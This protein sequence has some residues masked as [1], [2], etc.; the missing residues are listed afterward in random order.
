[1]ANGLLARK[2]RPVEH[3]R[4]GAPGPGVG[5]AEGGGSGGSLLGGRAGGGA[6][7]GHAG[8]AGAPSL[9]RARAHTPNGGYGSA[10]LQGGVRT[11]Y[12]PPPDP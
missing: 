2:L 11:P 5:A 9:V 12:R 7:R 4:A 1:M 10:P 8:E 3:V 6:G